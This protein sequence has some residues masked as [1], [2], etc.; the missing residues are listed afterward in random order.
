MTASPDAA[1]ERGQVLAQNDA[2]Y[3]AL[4]SADLDLMRAVWVPA[5]DPVCM[6]PGTTPVRGVAAVLRSW[7]LV[8]ANTSYIQFFLT[9]VEVSVERNVAAVTLT[10]N[11]LVPDPDPEG[12]F[13]GGRMAAVNVFLRTADGWRLWL[14]QAAPVGS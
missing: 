5:G 11:V 13:R 9:D 3:A 12:V 1:E 10:E 2:F 7:A 14:H 6:H 4:E 8:M